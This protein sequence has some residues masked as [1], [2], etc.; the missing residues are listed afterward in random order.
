M[1]KGVVKLVGG[2]NSSIRITN[3]QSKGKPVEYAVKML[4]I[5]QKFRMDNLVKADKVSRRTVD[6][7]TRLLIK[8]HCSTK[9]NSR[10]RRYGQPKFIKKKIDENFETL[11]KLNSEM[12]TYKESK[13]YKI[14][15]ELISFLGK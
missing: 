6:R 3:L 13:L 7:L 12:A 9:T 15:K 8:F 11:R 4:Q 5:P 1:Y 2:N 14:R 10:I